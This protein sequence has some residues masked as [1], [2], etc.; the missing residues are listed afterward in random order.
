MRP[1][2]KKLLIRSVIVLWFGAAGLAPAFAQDSG[3]SKGPLSKLSIHGFLTQA[4]ATSN[5]SEGGLFSPTVDEL[6][7]GIPEDGTFDYRAMALQFRYQMSPKDVFIVQLSSR[8]L[9]ESPINDEEDDIELD[10]AFYQRQLGDHTA[11]KIGRVQIPFGIFNELRDV[12]TVLP[13][14]R[15]PFVFYQEGNFTSETLDGLVFSHTFAP[16]S[17]WAL[18]ADVYLGEWDFFEVTPFVA[19]GGGQAFPAKAEDAYGFQLWLNTPTP[20]LRFGFGGHHRDV[21]GG[22]EGVPGVPG[23]G[24][25][26]PGETGSFDDWYVSVDL[27]T[28]KFVFRGEYREFDTPGTTIFFGGDFTLY[29]VQLG[30]HP[31]EKFRIYGQA[32]FGEAHH[33]A[34]EFIDPFGIP[35]TQD[36]DVDLRQDYGVALNYLFAPNLVLKLEHH[37]DVE[38]ELFAFLPFPVFTPQGPKLQPIF[39]NSTDGDYSILSFSVSF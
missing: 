20:S 35:A 31:T 16:S 12:G 10:W 21:T 1:T 19:A 24:F 7:L 6:Y 32:E 29:Y 9:G 25:R 8:S 30:F 38:G 39:A 33:D 14:Y 2:R 5:L 27:D 22:F 26:L 15:P 34:E 28:E 37:F 4:Y 3:S 18:E 36:I 11:I 23:S 17:N 13:F